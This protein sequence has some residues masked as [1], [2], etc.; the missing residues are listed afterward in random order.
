MIFWRARLQP[1]RP[2]PLQRRRPK[3]VASSHAG[4]GD[5]VFVAHGAALLVAARLREHAAELDLARVRR[6]AILAS[7]VRRFGT[8]HR[9]PAFEVP[10]ILVDD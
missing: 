9:A 4:V 1:R 2:A 5:Q 6:N 8:H 10:P 3:A 7:A